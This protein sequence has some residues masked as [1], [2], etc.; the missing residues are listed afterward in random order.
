MKLARTH[1]AI[2]QRRF[3]EPLLAGQKQIESRFMRQRRLPYGRIA[4]GDRIYFKASG[5]AVIGRCRVL[6]V[7]QY[8][9]LTPDD[10]RELRRSHQQA[11]CAPPDYWRSRRQCR[12][13]VLIWLGPVRIVP[14][15]A[16][17]PRQY[18]AGWAV[19]AE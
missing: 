15:F 8:D 14:R 17:P 18:G 1:L 2:I 12:F 9:R 7:R 11:I 10:F 19:L 5:G 16:P 6:R 4:V 3:V 13:G